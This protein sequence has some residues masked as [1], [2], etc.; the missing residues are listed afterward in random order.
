M[1]GR[2]F[3]LKKTWLLRGFAVL[4]LL[5]FMGFV[6]F[7]VLYLKI[8]NLWFYS[9]CLCVGAYEL[10]KGVM[11]KFDSAFYFGILLL[12]IGISGFNFYLLD[13]RSYAVFFIALAFILASISTFLVY[14]QKFH[15]IL[16]YSLTFLTLYGFLLRKNLITTPIFI[17]FVVY[18]LLQLVISIILNIKKGL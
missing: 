13:L 1:N 14:H 16:A 4:C 11:F 15:L 18:F 12:N 10:A 5:V 17:A 3:G 6:C 7:C 9:F 2:V 8:P